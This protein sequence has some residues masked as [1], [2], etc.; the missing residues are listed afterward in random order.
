MAFPVLETNRMKLIEI[1]SEYTDGYFE[2]MSRE[3]VTRYYG[4]NRLTDRD[5]AEEM[6]RSFSETFKSNRGIRWG[7]ILKDT[8]KF[9]GTIGLNNLSTYSKKAEIG[10]E[11]HPDFWRNGYISEAINEVLA[12]SYEILDLYRIG[13]VTFP[14]N[15]ASNH[16]LVKLGFEKEG[17]L[18]G[19]L[20]QNGRSHDA[21][22]FSYLKTDWEQR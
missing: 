18:R 14:Q 12:Y 19:Y 4:M 16:L 7:L 17:K 3:K 11:L 21:F 22:I 13:A 5:Q 9:I 8:R 2:I 10:Y 15:D 6:I 20:Y 1:G